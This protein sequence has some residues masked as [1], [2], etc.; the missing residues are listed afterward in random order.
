MP[1][2]TTIYFDVIKQIHEQ[3][4]RITYANGLSEQDRL[5]QLNRLENDL[6]QK[7]LWARRSISSRSE[8]PEMA[9]D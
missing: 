1:A 5:S 2:N 7:F 6:S 4:N 3:I 9:I 8:T